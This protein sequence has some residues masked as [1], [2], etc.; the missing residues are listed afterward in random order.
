MREISLTWAFF[1]AS[2]FVGEERPP[3]ENR[4]YPRPRAG[5]TS[6]GS[7]QARASSSSASST[8]NGEGR[9]SER[10]HLGD[11]ACTCCPAVTCD[12]VFRRPVFIVPF[13]VDV[14]DFAGSSP[15]LWDYRT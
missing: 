2:I 3:A 8:L 1:Y 4:W 13:I 15:G 7:A 11:T 9:D 5:Q 10:D 12:T 14:G 6:R